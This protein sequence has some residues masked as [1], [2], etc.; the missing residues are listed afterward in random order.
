ML[1]G[2]TTFRMWEL[3]EGGTGAFLTLGTAGMV[4]GTAGAG[5]EWMGC[6]KVECT[7]SAAS[8]S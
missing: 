7:C 4:G 8:V 6:A 5:R 1:G 3:E 2:N